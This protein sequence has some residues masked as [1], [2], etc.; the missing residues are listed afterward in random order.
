MT[1]TRQAHP[2]VWGQDAADPFQIGSR[3]EL[4]IDDHRVPSTRGR[5]G[6]QMHGPR[7]SQRC[8]GHR[9]Q[10]GGQRVHLTSVF[11]DGDRYR[12]YFGSLHYEMTEGKLIQGHPR[13]PVMPKAVTGSTGPTEPRTGG[14]RRFQEEQHCPGQG[15]IPGLVV[16][17]AHI[18][19]FKDS[20]PK[21]PPAEQYKA[22]IRP[23]RQKACTR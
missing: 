9:Q 14:I 4:M 2:V 11:Q 21:C 13:S 20:N 16:D 15:T 8:V 12:M 17:A 18:A 5:I 1:R 7:P 23:G 6:L 3:L 19:V 10:V 22:L